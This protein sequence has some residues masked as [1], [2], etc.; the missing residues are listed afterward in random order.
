MGR[1]TTGQATWAGPV[2]TGP[3]GFL[4][5]ALFRCQGPIGDPTSKPDELTRQGE[6]EPEDAQKCNVKVGSSGMI[7]LS[8]CSVCQVSHHEHIFFIIRQKTSKFFFNLS[9]P[10]PRVPSLSQLSSSAA[11]EAQWRPTEPMGTHGCLGACLPDSRLELLSPRP[12]LRACVHFTLQG[13]R[14][15]SVSSGAGC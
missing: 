14:S 8:S 4:C 7:F 1:A 6:V 15:A 2:G 10:F 5:A 13:A 11:L 9:R 12:G 3:S